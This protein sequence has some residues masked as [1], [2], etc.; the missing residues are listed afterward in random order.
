MYKLGIFLIG[1]CY[2]LTF[3]FTVN[4]KSSKFLLRRLIEWPSLKWKICGD[5]D[6]VIAS[7]KEIRHSNLG[8]ST[9]GRGATNVRS[10]TS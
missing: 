6:L 8:Q 4:T 3:L 1:H 10:S 9:N 5:K 2:C 7:N